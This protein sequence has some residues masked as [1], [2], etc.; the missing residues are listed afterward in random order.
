MPTLI[1]RIGRLERHTPPAT[2]SPDGIT[3]TWRHDG[4]AKRRSFVW[5][6]GLRTRLIPAGPVEVLAVEGG[7]HVEPERPAEPA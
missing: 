1:S 6:D 7:P 5:S 2:G 3:L 4:Q